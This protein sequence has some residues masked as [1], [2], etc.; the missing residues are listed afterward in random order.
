MYVCTYAYHMYVY[1]HLYM[2]ERVDICM[3][4]LRIYM[5]Y[6]RSHIHIANFGY[7]ATFT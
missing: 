3:H 1:L 5:A 6:V 2:H 7:S 4:I